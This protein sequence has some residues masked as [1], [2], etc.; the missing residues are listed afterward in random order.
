MTK[1]SKRCARSVVTAAVCVAVAGAAAGCSSS[2]GASTAAK[3]S[4]GI[5]LIKSGALTVCTHLPYKPFEFNQGGKVVGFDVSMLDLLSA[6]L[7]VKTKVIS[8]DWSQIVSGAAFAA[9]RCDVGAGAATVT[10]ERQKAV[11]FSKSYFDANQALM[12]KAGA[13]YT[14]LASLKGKKLGVQTATTGQVYGDKEA[15]TYGYQTVVYPDS[16]SLFN[17]VRAGAVQAA[18]ADNAPE[19]DFANNNPGVKVTAEFST[20]EHYGFMVKKNDADATKLADT[21]NAVL[22]QAQQDGTYTK[23]Y[24][25]WLG[26]APQTATK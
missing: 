23:I 13:S 5:S 1:I 8:M 7:G 3:S 4:D 21:L 19:L 2:S 24:K 15:K 11:Q 6:K 20:G 14:N 10:P 22:A 9:K 25:Q 18:I 16:L 17:A 26:R 12:V